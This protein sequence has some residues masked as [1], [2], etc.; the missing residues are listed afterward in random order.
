VCNTDWDS[1][2]LACGSAHVTHR[3]MSEADACHIASTCFHVQ[4]LCDVCSDLIAPE[5]MN[6]PDNFMMLQSFAPYRRSDA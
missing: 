3:C 2:S 6:Q 1:F 4:L 5:Y